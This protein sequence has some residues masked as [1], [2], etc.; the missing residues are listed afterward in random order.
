[1]EK[2][3]IVLII[4]IVLYYMHKLC[5]QSYIENIEKFT[6]T[7]FIATDITD[8]GIIISSAHRHSNT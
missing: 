2:Y 8:K 3:L 1:M 7:T 6:N 4:L 5:I